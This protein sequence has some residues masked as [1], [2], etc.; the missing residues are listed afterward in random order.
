MDTPRRCAH[1]ATYAPIR[2]V[3]VPVAG[4]DFGGVGGQHRQRGPCARGAAGHSRGTS[5][6]LDERVGDL[7]RGLAAELLLQRRLVTYPQPRRHRGHLR[8]Q[9]AGTPASL[10]ARRIHPA[11][12]RPRAAPRGL[13]AGTRGPDER[14]DPAL[15]VLRTVSLGDIGSHLG[16]PQRDLVRFSHGQRDLVGFSHGQR[17]LVRFSHGLNLPAIAS[18]PRPAQLGLYRV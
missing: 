3:T 6:A 17:D 13:R 9:P 4:R 7:L 5:R 2:S 8:G 12:R 10:A 16:G 18:D 1:D 14:G 15:P 11:P